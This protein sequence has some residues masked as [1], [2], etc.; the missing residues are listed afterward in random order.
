MVYTAET[1]VTIEE[2]DV[3][4]INPSI[5]LLKLTITPNPGPMKGI[6]RHFTFEKKGP[7]V[8]QY[9]QVQVVSNQGESCTVNIS[10]FG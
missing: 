3:Q 8:S 10:V 4:G 5:L 6:P 9:T 7:E 2:A 1:E